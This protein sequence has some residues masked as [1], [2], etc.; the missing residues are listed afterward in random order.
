MKPYIFLL[1][2][3]LT[4]KAVS[5]ADTLSKSTLTT[6]AIV[7]PDTNH[8]GYKLIDSSITS[9]SD[10]EYKQI[11]SILKICILE[12]G[13][14]SPQKKCCNRIGNFEYVKQIVPFKKDKNERVIWVNCI[15]TREIDSYEKQLETYNKIKKKNKRTY[16][17]W[18]KGWTKQLIEV[19]DGGNCWWNVKINLTSRKYY[20]LHV[21]GPGS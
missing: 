15:C 20:D 7:L 21:N 14:N 9:F 16:V 12:N 18:Y 10:K 6:Y 5:Q 8:W 4:T 17:P 1:L 3:I 13:Q 19:D 2:V 11:D